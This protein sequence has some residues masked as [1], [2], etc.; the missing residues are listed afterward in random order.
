MAKLQLFIGLS[1]LAL[2]TP[3]RVAVNGKNH[4]PKWAG[5]AWFHDEDH[6]RGARSVKIVTTQRLECLNFY[7]IVTIEDA[8]FLLV[9]QEEKR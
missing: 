1:F 4:N 7:C 9:K 8:S 5:A 6:Q 3:P 2:S